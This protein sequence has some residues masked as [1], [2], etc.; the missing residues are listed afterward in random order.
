MKN[1]S[2]TENCGYEEEMPQEPSRNEKPG[3]SEKMKELATKN[4]NQVKIINRIKT[5]S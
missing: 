2:A 1:N 4:P 3:E 5:E